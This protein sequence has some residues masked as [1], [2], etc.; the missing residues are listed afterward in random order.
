MLSESCFGVGIRFPQLGQ[1]VGLL[2]PSP[3]D[4]PTQVQRSSVLVIMVLLQSFNLPQGSR[5]L[6]LFFALD[7]LSS[8]LPLPMTHLG[9]TKNIAPSNPP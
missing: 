3:T 5:I 4:E 7:L 9:T 2:S 8:F 1:I 6:P